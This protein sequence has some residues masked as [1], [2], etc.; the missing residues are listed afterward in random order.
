METVRKLLV[1]PLVFFTLTAGSAFGEQQPH[2][3]NPNQLSDAM[4]A[5]LTS[6]DAN[7]AAVRE[8]LA[9]PEVKR[10]AAG[11]GVDANRLTAA[12]DTLAG[13]DLDQAASAARQVNQ[14]LV[15]GDSVVISTTTI[16]I[17][18]LIIILIVVA[19]H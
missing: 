18:L 19:V 16:I 2:I 10:I 1:L 4:T 9:R 14:R 5:H 15:G 6:Q 12:A 3:V 11:M 7:R 8:A 17:A 13:T